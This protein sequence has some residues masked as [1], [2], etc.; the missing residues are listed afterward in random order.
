MSLFGCQQNFIQRY[1]SMSSLQKVT[2]M[3]MSNIPVIIVLF[4]LSWVA[5]IGIF[6]TYFD[7][8]PLLANI[9]KKKDEL[10]PYFV[11][12]QFDYLPGFIGVFMACLFNGALA[13]NVSNINSLATVTWEDFLSKLPYFKL[14]KEKHQLNII[15][16]VGVVYA[17]LIMGVGFSVGLLSG[18]IE[19]Q[20]LMTSATSGPL[21]GAFLLAI[22][23]PM[24]NW[25]GTAS[26]MII[27]QILTS[28]LVIG[29]LTMGQTKKSRL[30][31]SI[32]GCSN[33]TLSFDSYRHK[34]NYWNMNNKPQE[35]Q[36]ENFYSVPIEKDQNL[37]PLIQL[38][39]TSYMYYS[40]FGTLLTVFI[41]IVISW[42]TQSKEDAYES[43]LIHPMVLRFSN[44]L[45]GKKRYYTDMSEEIIKTEPVVHD[46]HAYENSETVEKVE[47]RPKDF[48]L[49][50]TIV[51]SEIYRKIT[52]D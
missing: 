7:C 13:L 10:L 30:E 46:N 19:S 49:S 6:A 33:D 34:F 2:K 44:W 4:S 47:E 14:K 1:L 38:Y 25:K 27:A 50:K 40:I 36:Y 32:D 20:M 52:V 15:K 45:P 43:K 28:W 9:T 3:M 12:E 42:M 18:V 51:P 24:A 35:I 16:F 8:D 23:F 26:G 29:N 21:L 39:S 31:T 22:L 17:V 41:G 48:E 5:G 37:S 11:E